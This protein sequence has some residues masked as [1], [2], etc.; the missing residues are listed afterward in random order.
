MRAKGGGRKLQF[1]SIYE[2]IRTWVELERSHCHTVLPRHVGWKFHEL[3]LQYH[4]E[5]QGKDEKGSISNEEKKDLANS[6][7]MLKVLDDPKNSVRR[8]LHIIQSI[9]AKIRSPNLTTQL[10]DVE[11]QIRA[12]LSWNQ[13]DFQI[14]RIA[15][16][17]DED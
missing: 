1:P 2:Q 6:T 4:Q 10:S 15:Q 3:L 8:A 11:Q 16:M 9:G 5:L 14:W 12:E 13:H 17:K 7:K